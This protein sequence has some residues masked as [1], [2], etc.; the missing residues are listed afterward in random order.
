ML[1]RAARRVGS[2]TRRY[3]APHEAT[4]A[5]R[6]FS[7]TEPPKDDENDVDFGFDDEFDFDLSLDA[8]LDAALSADG[9]EDVEG[10]ELVE[11]QGYNSMD[12]RNF[13]QP[14]IDMVPAYQAYEDILDIR[15][16]PRLRPEH[17][18]LLRRE[19]TPIDFSGRYDPQM[20]AHASKVAGIT[21]RIKEVA[22]ELEDVY[23]VQ[24]NHS[25]IS[26]ASLM[27][28]DP[29]YEAI[30]PT[31]QDL[32]ELEHE[33]K[34][35]EPPLAHKGACLFCQP[36]PLRQNELTVTNVETLRRFVNQRGMI[37]NRKYSNV[38]AKHQRKL[39]K[40]I[41]RARVMGLLS[42]TSNWC[43]PLSFLQGGSATEIAKNMQ[44]QNP[45]ITL[46]D[47]TL[48][49]YE[50]NLDNIDHEPDEDEDD[51]VENVAFDR[52]AVEYLTRV[53]DP[54]PEVTS[55]AEEKTRK[56]K[57]HGSYMDAKRKKNL[58]RKEERRI[59]DAAAGKKK[60]LKKGSRGRYM[61]RSRGQSNDFDDD[62]RDDDGNDN[63]QGRYA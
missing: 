14:G 43:V 6:A 62:F 24:V 38:C 33:I 46:V 8:T 36:D 3:A 7:T 48:K 20:E 22:Q 34:K 41:K 45:A 49:E 52:P 15:N 30:N 61:E 37:V 25:E 18:A 19:H 12:D 4:Q 54:D 60:F 59:R 21:S 10:K 50:S 51:G 47:E 17:Y 16:P 44:R 26:Q 23:G 5:A 31:T 57:D 28:E 56:Y 27:P 39:E 29:R 9:I 55:G 11:G 2:S 32:G 40:M 1:L 13:R 53:E 63:D 35:L 42:Y 58:E